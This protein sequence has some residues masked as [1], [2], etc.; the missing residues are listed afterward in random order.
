MFLDIFNRES[1]KN[2]N[3]QLYLQLYNKWYKL[4]DLISNVPPVHYRSWH[5]KIP[6]DFDWNFVKFS[7][8]G[9]RKVLMHLLNFVLQRHN[10]VTF[11]TYKTVAQTEEKQVIWIC[12]EIWKPRIGVEKTKIF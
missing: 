3:S 11:V 1:L 6:C 9:V 4:L 8:R 2:Q 10:D 7:I 12:D 5:F